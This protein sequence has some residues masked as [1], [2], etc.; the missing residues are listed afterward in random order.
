MVITLNTYLSKVE[1]YNKYEKNDMSPRTK[2]ML[3]K[4]LMSQNV[5][6]SWGGNRKLLHAF[7][8]QGIYMLM[9]VLNGNR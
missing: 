5:T 7:A 8:E 6:S 2:D 1:L 3:I 4:K 9:T